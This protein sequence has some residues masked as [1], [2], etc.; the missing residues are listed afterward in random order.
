MSR[1]ELNTDK[2]PTKKNL[3]EIGKTYYDLTCLRFF[4]RNKNNN[5]FFEYKCI[6]GKNHIAMGIHVRTGSIKSCGCRLKTNP[7]CPRRLEYGESSFNRM[8]RSYKYHAKKRGYD[9]LLNKEEFKN[10]TKKNCYFCGEEPREVRNDKNS[11]GLY[12]GNGI[13]RL[14]NTLGYSVENCVPCCG[15]CNRAKLGRT[16][17]EYIDHIKRVY[18]FLKKENRI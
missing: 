17:N 7:G 16:E 10:I 2:K 18:K 5:A 14:D 11:N 1:Q 8:F 4:G 6:C 13:D 15:E 12:V 3:E 9:F